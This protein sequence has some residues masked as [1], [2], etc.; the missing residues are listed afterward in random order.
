MN[1]HP[2]T[3]TAAA[4]QEQS[5]RGTAWTRAVNRSS[6]SLVHA[7]YIAIAVLAG[8]FGVWAV[9]A[10]L[11][12]AVIAPGVVAAAGQNVVIQHLEGG[13]VSEIAVKEG[14]RVSAGQ[15]LIRLDDTLAKVSLNRLEKQSAGLHAQILRLEAERDNRIQ[16]LVPEDHPLAGNENFEQAMREQRSQFEARLGRH[17]TELNIIRQRKIAL[18]A[19]ETGLNA[20]KKALADQT[21]VVS[22]EMERKKRLLDRGLTNRSEYTALLRTE[23]DLAGRQGDMES[24]LARTRIQVVEAQEQLERLNSQRVETAVTELT[25]A[26]LKLGDILEQI[27]AA[28]DVL[29]RTTIRSNVDGIVVRKLVNAPGTVIAP[30]NPIMEI[31]PTTEELIVETQINPRDIDNLH[32]GQEAVLRF[33]GLN[34][35][36]TPEYPAKVVYLSADRITDKAQ[37]VSF[38]VARLK[39]DDEAAD[40]L[41]QEQVYPGMPVEAFIGT[42]SRTF[43][44]Y[45]VKPLLDSINR[46]FRE[47]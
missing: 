5:E 27:L 36:T 9:T 4:G 17:H 1:A 3:I 15:P 8:T 2:G 38:F 12:G 26:R 20:Q 22:D 6:G 24:Q 28:R 21:A 46:A 19:N 10:P 32:I 34:S 42:D 11:S 31:L 37:E 14:D 41:Y 33:S 39:I 43:A 45:L 23:A 16:V 47:E 7:G 35:R 40:D 13:I 18:E 29:Q 25:E 44:E 30:G